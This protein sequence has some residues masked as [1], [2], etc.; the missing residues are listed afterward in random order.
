MPSSRRVTSGKHPRDAE[1]A[2]RG[3]QTRFRRDEK[4]PFCRPEQRFRRAEARSD[5]AEMV[6]DE[7]TK[8]NR[9]KSISAAFV[10]LAIG[11]SCAG[12]HGRTAV[13]WRYNLRIAMWSI[14]VSA[15]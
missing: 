4:R 10:L 7:G 12:D 6:F 1:G 9:R 5:K 2:F 14:A 15:M 3:A 13:A 11:E 8:E